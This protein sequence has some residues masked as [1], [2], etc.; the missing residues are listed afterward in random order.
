MNCITVAPH[1]VTPRVRAASYYWQNWISCL[2]SSPQ[3]SLVRPSWVYI[4]KRDESPNTIRFNSRSHWTRWHHCN[5]NFS[6]ICW[7][8]VRWV[9][10][11]KT[12]SK[13]NPTIKWSSRELL[14]WGSKPF[15]Y[16]IDLEVEN[17]F[18]RARLRGV[19]HGLYLYDVVA[20]PFSR[21]ILN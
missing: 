13:P 9:E 17:R 3:R 2:S 18:L 4:Q 14:T 11:D 21:V 20:L 6:Q 12:A 7:T 1:N 16:A 10:V 19:L 5:V 8:M 15:L